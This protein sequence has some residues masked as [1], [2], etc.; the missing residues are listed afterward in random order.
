MGAVDLVRALI[1]DCV[2]IAADGNLIWCR[3]ADARYFCKRCRK[4]AV[5]ERRKA[6]RT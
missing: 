2:K 3:R 5:Q 6:L 4:H 1:A